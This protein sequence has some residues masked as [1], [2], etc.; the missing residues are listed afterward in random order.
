MPTPAA[1]PNTIAIPSTFT[2]DEGTETAGVAGSSSRMWSPPL[3]TSML[4]VASRS[5]FCREA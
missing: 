2:H 4:S 1:R 5:V 3:L